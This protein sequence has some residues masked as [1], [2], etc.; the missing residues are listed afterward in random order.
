M[1]IAST[2]QNRA[3]QTSRFA[4]PTGLAS[5]GPFRLFGRHAPAR[6]RS[7]VGVNQRDVQRPAGDPVDIAVDASRHFATHLELLAHQLG[8]AALQAGERERLAAALAGV[9]WTVGW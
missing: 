9:Q 5:V 4:G 6:R 1:P 2:V 3:N 7:V 8:E